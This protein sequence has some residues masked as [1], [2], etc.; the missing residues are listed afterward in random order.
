MDIRLCV[1]GET[2]RVEVQAHE[3]LLYVLRDKLGFTEVKNGCERGECGSCTVL[4]DGKAVVSCLMLAAKADGRRITTAKGLARNGE[5]HILQKKFIEHEAIQ[6]GYCT[7]GMLLSAKALLDA[8]P[9]PTEEEVRRALAGNICRCTGY[10]QI[11]EAVLAASKE[12]GNSDE[13]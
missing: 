10:Q 13:Q 1:N 9:N 7:P 12:I 5:L 6:C 4:L 3:T 8:H 2:H 11:V